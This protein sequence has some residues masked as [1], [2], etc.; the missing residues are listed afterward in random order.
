LLFWGIASLGSGTAFTN[1]DTIEK[2]A[3][4]LL[5]SAKFTNVDTS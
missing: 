5:D 4:C 1:A 2:I 3:Y